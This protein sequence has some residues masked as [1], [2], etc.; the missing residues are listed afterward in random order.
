LAASNPAHREAVGHLHGFAGQLVTTS[1]VV[2]E[3][4]YFVSTSAT[5][6][7][8]LAEFVGASGVRV[9]EF[10]QARASRAAATLMVQ[11]ADSP[12]N[13]ADATLVLPAETLNANDILTL[14]RRG[15]RLCFRPEHNDSGR[16]CYRC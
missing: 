4:M 3:A 12:M 1:A 8:L 7:R 6:A 5:G 15:H 2:T 11:Y 16:V 9:Y 14:D 13:Y 10:S